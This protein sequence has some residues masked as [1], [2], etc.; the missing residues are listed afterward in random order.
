M[1]NVAHFPPP[2][3]TVLDRALIALTFAFK[4]AHFTLFLGLACLAA[5]LMG[6]PDLLMRLGADVAVWSAMFLALIYWAL[7][8]GFVRYPPL[9]YSLTAPWRL[10]TRDPLI[11]WSLLIIGVNALSVVILA[12]SLPTGADV[13]LAQVGQ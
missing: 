1:E 3:A 10:L 4:V 13:F 2:P 5:R 8:S 11:T 6:G 9:P 7:F 12:S